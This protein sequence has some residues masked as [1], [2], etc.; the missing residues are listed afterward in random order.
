MVDVSMMVASGVLIFFSGRSKMF[1]K[2]RIIIKGKEA[3]RFI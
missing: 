3:K 2:Y 1:M